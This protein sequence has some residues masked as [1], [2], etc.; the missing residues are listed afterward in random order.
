MTWYAQQVFAQPLDGVIAAFR[1]VPRLAD[2]IYH[3]P[4]LRDM[5]SVEQV[6][7]GVTFGGGEMVPLHRPGR[8]GPKLPPGGLLV[9]RE[10]CGSTDDHCAE[11]F[12]G[13]GVCWDGLGAAS[14]ASEDPLLQ[15]KTVFADAP[16][17]W[18]TVAPP[19]S[20]L[21][22][23]QSIAHGTRSVVAYYACHMWGGDVECNFAWV[24]DG[25]KRSSCF[26]RAIV[27]ANK[28]GIEATGFYTDLTGVYAVDRSGRHEILDGDVLT[29]VLLHFGLMLRDGYFELHTRGF[30]WH[31]YKLPSVP[32]V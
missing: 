3:V 24:W 27:S 31:K 18:P 21:L 9:V 26:Y 17:W 29:L 32:P 22:Q 12:G 5:E 7:D 14:S 4:H 1:E 2:A 30:P 19:V 16:D 11:W 23:L 8:R 15:F 28:K 25:E 20:L 6:Q 13:D 10:L